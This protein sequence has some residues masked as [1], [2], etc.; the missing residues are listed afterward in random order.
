[1]PERKPKRTLHYA[2][3]ET[4][5]IRLSQLA[6]GQQIV[7]TVRRSAGRGKRKHLVIELPVGVQCRLTRVAKM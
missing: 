1:M 3:G 4:A 6:I 7:L 5:V 2:T